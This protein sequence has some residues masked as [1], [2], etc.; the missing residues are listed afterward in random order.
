[1]TFGEGLKRFRM[2]TGLTQLALANKLGVKVALYQRY[3]WGQT[4]PSVDFAIKVARTFGIS[5][6]YLLGLSDEP[7]PK[8]YDEVEIQEA[9]ALRD[10]LKKIMSKGGELIRS[11]MKQ[12]NSAKTLDA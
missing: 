1:M 5:A 9:F 8:K 6:D 7:Y 4:V 2:T 12:N 11:P 3:E 10:A